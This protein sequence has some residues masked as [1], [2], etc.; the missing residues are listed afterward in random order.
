MPF[1]SGKGCKHAEI[2]IK[3]QGW[4]LWCAYKEE[5]RAQ[6]MELLT[7][8]KIDQNEAGKRLAVSVRQIKRIVRRYRTEGLPRSI[9]TNTESS[10]STQKRLTRRRKPSS[11]GQRESWVSN[12]STPT[13]HRQKFVWNVPTRPC[14]VD[15]SRKCVWQES[16][17]WQRP[18]LGYLSLYVDKQFLIFLAQIQ[19]I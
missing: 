16:I 8:G 12:A 14:R 7:A 4:G 9:A 18:T 11:R 1:L 19:P 15:W 3:Q 10:V 6:V 2:E 5:I 13:A 17:T